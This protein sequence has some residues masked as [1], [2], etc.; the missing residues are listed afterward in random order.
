MQNR[1]YPSWEYLE[2]QNN[3]LTQGER[4]LVEYLDKFLPRDDQWVL[5]DSLE[6]YKGWIIF[7]QPFLNG[8]RP[9]VIIF[10]PNVG[11]IIYEVKDWNL[12]NYKYN[13]DDR[14]LYVKNSNGSYKIKNP[15]SQVSYY[16][17]K[18]IEQLVP[19]IGNSLT[20]PG[21]YPYIQT[22]VYFHYA[23]T[24]DCNESLSQSVKGHSEDYLFGNDYLTEKRLE[25]VV[26]LVT[27]TENKYWDK[28]WNKEIF[29]WLRPPFHS[30]EQTTKLIIKGNQIKAAEP[31]EGHHR[32]R[33]VAGSGKTL[34]LALRAAK[35]A[36]EGY[37]VLIVTFN[38]TLWHYIKDMIKRA[39]FEFEWELITFTHFHG[40]CKDLL[41]E[42]GRNWPT[43]PLDQ[44]GMESFFAETVPKSVINAIEGKQYQKYD[45]ILIDEGQDFHFEWYDLL[46]KYFLTSRDELVIVCDKKQN[47]F[48]RNLNWLDKRVTRNGIE[49]FKDNYIDLTI[50]FRLPKKVALMSN[51]FSEIFKLD[52]ELKTGKIDDNPVLFHSQHIIWLNISENEL[53]YYINQSYDKLKKEGYSASDIVFLFNKHKIGC[54]AVDFFRNKGIEVNHVFENGSRSNSYSHKKS[55]WMG[56]GRLKMSTIHSFKGWELLNIVLYISPENSFEKNNLDSLYYTAMTRTRENIIVLNA[57]TK[58]NTFGDKL[59]KVWEDQ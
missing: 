2:K 54:Q 9:D 29:F 59:P 55:F 25:A 12:K 27:I 22:K 46:N 40:L 10:N 35:L 41:N 30:L 39:P 37:N 21:R 34:A 49:K 3:P 5:K 23:T 14:E 13:P 43:S 32:V 57:N 45:A 56:D 52:Q 20:N 31:N 15:V 11:L 51:E 7:V 16:K 26:P 28:K 38:I 6:N 4:A 44:I 53:E 36:S 8:T 50:T 47:I 42:F 17:N 19:E 48:E 1:I 24:V 18:L 33:G 58:Y